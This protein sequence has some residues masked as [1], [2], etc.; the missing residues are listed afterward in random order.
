MFVSNVFLWPFRGISEARRAWH[1][2]RDTP[3]SLVRMNPQKFRAW[4]EEGIR[5]RRA[6]A[7]ARE[8]NPWLEPKR[9]KRKKS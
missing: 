7:E 9:R 3:P 1:L 8:I 6:E 5:E 4:V 2:W